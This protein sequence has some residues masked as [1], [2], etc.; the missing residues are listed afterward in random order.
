VAVQALLH[1]LAD[2]VD[3]RQFEA[4]QNLRQVT[5]RDDDEPVRLWQIGAGKAFANLVAQHALDL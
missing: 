3:F 5:L 2:A 4:E 1:A